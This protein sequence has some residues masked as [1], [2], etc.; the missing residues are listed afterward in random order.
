MFDDEFES[1]QDLEIPSYCDLVTSS[2]IYDA[3]FTGYNSI[4]L[5]TFGKNLLFFCP[6]YKL[7]EESSEYTMCKDNQATLTKKNKK[8]P[9]EQKCVYEL[10]KELLFKHSIMGLCETYLSDNVALDLAVFTLNGISVWQYEPEKLIDH[11]NRLITNEHQQ[12]SQQIESWFEMGHDW[13][14]KKGL[15]CNFRGI[16]VLSQQILFVHF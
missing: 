2:A 15:G 8:Q 10:R 14:D 5:G 12:Q 1:Y 13:S 3:T 9:H 16:F 11:L 4:V 6:T 7:L